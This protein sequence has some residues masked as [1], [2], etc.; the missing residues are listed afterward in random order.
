VILLITA[1]FQDWIN[2]RTV[3]QNLQKYYSKT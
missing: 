2:Y 1:F 3:I